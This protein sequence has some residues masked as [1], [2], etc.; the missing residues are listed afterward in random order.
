[1]NNEKDK[2]KHLPPYDVDKYG[3]ARFCLTA[4]I[5]L[6]SIID[7]ELGI[8]L[9]KRGDPTGP[10]YKKW[11]LPG[12]FMQD[13]D[14]TITDTARRELKEETGLDNIYLEQLECFS[15]KGRDPREFVSV[16]PTRII[17]EAHLALIDHTKVKAI[18]GDDA[19][20]VKW[21]K[22]SE[23][24]E[25]AFDHKEIINTALNRVRNKLNY[26]NVG[27]ELVPD[28]F[29]IPELRETFEKVTG[30]KINK[31]N[32][33][34]KILKLKIL[35]KTKMKRI[36]GKGQPAPLYSLDKGRFDKL[37]LGETLF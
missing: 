21:Y 27:F 15:K 8:L 26:T 22:V 33:R 13:D 32:F 25:L 24:P 17:S 20:D 31:S 29:T 7:N 30:K 2:W 4:D 10:Y 12:G 37:K 6:L 35:K 19:S 11:A 5:V 36:I 1:M 3:N 9:I 23:L 28:V 16:R 14:E 18:A 34:T